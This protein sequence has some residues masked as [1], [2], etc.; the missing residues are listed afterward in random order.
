MI[1]QSRLDRRFAFCVLLLCM[2]LVFIWGN[3]LLPGNISALLSL[4]VLQWLRIHLPMQRM[5]V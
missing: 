3:S 5:W 2:N 4:L 1:R